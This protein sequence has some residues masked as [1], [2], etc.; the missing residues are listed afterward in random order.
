[1]G[2]PPAAGCGAA[3]APQMERGAVACPGNAGAPSPHEPRTLFY[4]T[5]F[6]SFAQFGRK[7]VQKGYS[8]VQK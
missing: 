2:K 7:I 4:C 1:M 6:S 5:I 3:R 8:I